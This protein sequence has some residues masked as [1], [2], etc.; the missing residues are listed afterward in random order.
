MT[1]FDEDLAAESTRLRNRIRG[2][3]T[4]IHPTLERVVGR[5]LE[6]PA[7]LALL[8]AFPTPSMMAAAGRD[9]LLEVVKPHAPRMAERPHRRCADRAD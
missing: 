1:G 9:V 6:H 7:V 4:Q 8:E 5:R 3:L 2:L